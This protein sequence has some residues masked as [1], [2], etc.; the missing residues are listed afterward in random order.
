MA[1]NNLEYR[2]IRPNSTFLLDSMDTKSDDAP[3]ELVHDHEYPVAI[4]ENRFTP[5][6]INAPQAV[7]GV[8]EEGQPRRS[9]IYQDL[10]GNA[11]RGCA[12]PHLYRY[13]FETLYLSAAL[14]VG[15]QTVG[16]VVL[17]R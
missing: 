7:F 4:Q 16:C 8:P 5:K 10:T 1:Q 3:S 9:S 2:L 15:S 13:W 12:A 14:S 6:Q 17:L 11:R